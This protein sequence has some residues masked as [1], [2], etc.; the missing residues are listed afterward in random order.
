VKLTRWSIALYV[1]LVFLSGAVLGAFAHRAYTASAV[2]ANAPI[3]P[4]EYRKRYLEELKRR[5]KV[6]DEQMPK[7]VTILEATR[8][9]VRKTRD[10]IEPE[11]QRIREDQQAQIHAILSPEQAVEYDKMRKERDER[12]KKEGPPPR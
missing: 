12:R 6:S 8:A 10:S 7:I 9:A 5:V 1:A 4:E 3:T 11:L 2:S